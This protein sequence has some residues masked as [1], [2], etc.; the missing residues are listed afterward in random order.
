MLCN[1]WYVSTIVIASILL[2]F[3]SAIVYRGRKEHLSLLLCGWLF[4]AVAVYRAV[5]PSQYETRSVWY[6]TIANSTMV[7][8]CIAIFAEISFAVLMFG[9]YRHQGI[10]SIFVTLFL[11]MIV[12]AQIPAT[13]GAYYS[14]GWLYSM[15]ETMWALG[16]IFLLIPTSFLVGK[17]NFASVM[18]ISLLIYLLFQGVSLYGKW[19]KDMGKLSDVSWANF[20]NVNRMCGKYGPMFLIWHTGYFVLLSILVVYLQTRL[21]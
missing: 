20:D 5:L 17:S 2:I 13:F 7:I 19:S 11:S 4:V 9:V 15:E 21:I 18:L 8:R 14:Y 12:L 1:A 16:A 6:K 10:N 3:S